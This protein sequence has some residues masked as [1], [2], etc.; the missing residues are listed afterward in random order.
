MKF[1]GA[2]W[3][4]LAKLLAP[5]TN[6]AAALMVTCTV[7]EPVGGASRYHNSASQFVPLEARPTYVSARL[8]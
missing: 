1:N 6:L 2:A 3:F 7:N 4:T 8:L 5:A